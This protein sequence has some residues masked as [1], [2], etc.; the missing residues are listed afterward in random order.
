MA[1]QRRD[2][3]EWAIPGGMRD[4][5]EV[6]TK[7]LIREFAE[8]ALSHPI[9]FDKSDK[10]TSTD[11]QKHLHNIKENLDKKLELFFRNGTQVPEYFF[12]TI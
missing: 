6:I 1:I 2:T 12:F 7:T 8:E 3:K 9:K 11:D 4:P 10:I 5:G